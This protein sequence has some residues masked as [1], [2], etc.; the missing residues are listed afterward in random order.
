M[1]RFGKKALSLATSSFL[2]ASLL[3][4]GS[5]GVFADDAASEAAEVTE[6]AAETAEAAEGGSAVEELGK[7]MA[8]TFTVK[9]PILNIQKS[10]IA[11][12]KSA[13]IDFEFSGYLPTGF[14]T[15]EVEGDITAATDLEAGAMSVEGTVNYGDMDVDFTG[16]IDE[17][18]VVVSVPMFLG[19][20]A[21]SYDFSEDKLDN[22][23]TSIVGE[24]T[25]KELN[26]SLRTVMSGIK[27]KAAAGEAEEAFSAG[28]SEAMVNAFSGFW[29][30]LNFEGPTEV[31]FN[32]GKADAYK[33][34]LTAGNLASL[35]D[36]IK[37][38]EAGGMTFT[39][40]FDMAKS[41]GSVDVSLEDI[42]AAIAEMPDLAYTYYVTDGYCAGIDVAAAEDNSEIIAMRFKGEGEPWRDIEFQM[43]GETICDIESTR[44]DK[45]ENF[46]LTIGDEVFASM[47]YDT[48][49]KAYAL[50][51]PDD[52]G[53]GTVEGIFGVDGD[54]FALGVT[55]LGYDGV[56]TIVPGAEVAAPTEGA[57]ELTT[58][59][60]NDFAALFGMAEEEPAA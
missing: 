44:E 22:Y 18:K 46:V 8:A 29:T 3:V 5:A 31:D 16:Y 51:L 21:L 42:D 1:K 52:L 58:A 41:S 7:A 9:E 43:G 38:V 14:D 19:E 36:S 13:T 59:T 33:T 55:A 56:L 2:A 20:Q 47:S 54:E 50:I 4:G 11:G 25:I 40:I 57:L 12:T 39:Q 35:W 30:G 45:T 60:E 23:L 28:A 27:A 6:S 10:E 24:D 48:E 17:S 32:G 34:V 37:N 53:L 49:S 26:N 15:V